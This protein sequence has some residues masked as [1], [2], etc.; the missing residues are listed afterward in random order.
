MWKLLSIFV[1]LGFGPSNKKHAPTT[2]LSPLGMWGEVVGKR[3]EA[4][5][6]ACLEIC[7]PRAGAKLEDELAGA[8]DP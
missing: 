2:H 8:S 3:R 4:L 1:D 7:V 6:E 5:R